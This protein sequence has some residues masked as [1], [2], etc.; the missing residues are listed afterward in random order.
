MEYRQLG[1]SGLKVPVLSFGTLTLGGGSAFY[2]ACGDLSFSEAQCLIDMCIDAGVTLFDTADVYSQGRSEEILGK[3]I[4]HKRDQV[5]IATKATFQTGDGPN[6]KG[7]SR[8]HLLRACDAQLKRLNTDYID[9]YQMHGF[10]PTTPIDEVL[11]TLETLIQSGKVRYIGCSN[12]S[13]WHLMKSL[14]IADKIGV[15]RY[16]A[17]QVHYSLIGRDYEHELM[18]LA[19]EEG[20]GALIWSPLGFGR[21]TGKINKS[22]PLPALS[23][24]HQTKEIAPPV[25]DE[26]LFNTIDALT[27]IAEETGKTVPQVALNWLLQRPTVSSIILGARTPLQLQDNLG[28]IGWQLTEAQV[29]RLAD[30]SAQRVP[31]PYWHQARFSK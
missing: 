31:Y 1:A 20:I 15:N 23:R 28:A 21:L 22:V 7:S 25:T 6:D 26:L 19:K 9:L 10:D 2:K 12:F 3:A 17:H 29:K 14:G 27:D 13:G 24:L 30:I 18:P 8:Y 16:A 4:G 5:M 11:R